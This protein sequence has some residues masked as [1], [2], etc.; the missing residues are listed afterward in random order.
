MSK[1]SS[2]DEMRRE[3]YNELY[4]YERETDRWLESIQNA[5]AE[6]AD[7]HRS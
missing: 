6:I 3:Y 4:A 2:D 5:E 1:P 7:S